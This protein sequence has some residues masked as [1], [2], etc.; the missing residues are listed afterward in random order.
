MKEKTT[1]R[2]RRAQYVASAVKTDFVDI[3]LQP[4]LFEEQYQHVRS[5]NG[6]SCDLNTDTIQKVVTVSLDYKFLLSPGDESSEERP[7]LGLTTRVKVYLRLLD[8]QSSSFARHNALD[9]KR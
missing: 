5:G 9:H 6:A 2:A 8:E 1:I 7:Q 3:C 4:I